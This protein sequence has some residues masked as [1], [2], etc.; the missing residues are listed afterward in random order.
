MS[1]KYL[2]FSDFCGK[3]GIRTPEPVL[4]V[5]RFLYVM[6]EALAI[7]FGSFGIK[8]DIFAGIHSLITDDYVASLTYALFF[9]AIHAV[10]GVWMY[11]KKIF[12]KL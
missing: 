2:I 8:A 5:T 12:I 7:L 10:M 3:R 9:V 1:W 4:P 6:S 11:H